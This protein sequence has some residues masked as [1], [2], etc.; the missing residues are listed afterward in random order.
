MSALQ[1]SSRC[2]RGVTLTVLLALV[3]ALLVIASSSTSAAP[4]GRYLD[5]IFSTKRTPDLVYG[6][7]EHR[8][9]T[10][11]RLRLDLYRPVGDRRRNRPA[12]IFIHGGTSSNDKAFARNRL[13]PRRMAARGMVGAS[14]DYR[15]GTVGFTREAQHD[16]RAAVRFLKARAGR[17]GIDPT[18]IV[19]IGSSS[20]AM[21]AL[22]VA[23][24][25][26]DAGDSGHPGQS[27]TVAGAISIGGGSTEPYDIT[28]DEVPI[29]MIHAEDDTVVPVLAADAT[30]EQTKAMGNVCEFFRY[31]EGGHPPGFIARHKNRLIEQSAR[32][33]CRHVIGLRGCRDRNDDGR[34][35]R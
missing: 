24:D 23:F 2:C 4:R 3:G 7:V 35:D 11:E 1:E 25:P 28:A 9:G 16:T 19:L 34:V 27:S 33:M 17:Y 5:E 15:D 26:E 20:G 13:I 12:V 21:D 31:A 10:V 6:R 8:D 30:C 32:F 22:N 29:A 14:I 18:K